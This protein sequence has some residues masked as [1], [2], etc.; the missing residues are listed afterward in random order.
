MAA[1]DHLKRAANAA[2]EVPSGIIG[3]FQDEYNPQQ[4]SDQKLI[5]TVEK[6]E[7][8]LDKLGDALKELGGRLNPK[9]KTEQPK[10][11]SKTDKN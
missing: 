5:L 6:I 11:E 7:E 8:D 4:M 9:P 2:N 1:A 3:V 10:T